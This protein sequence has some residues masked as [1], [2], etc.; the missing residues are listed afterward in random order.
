MSQNR[1]NL[2]ARFLLEVAAL[3]SMGYWG[4]RQGE[5]A[6]RFLIMLGV[7]IFAAALW[8]IFRVPGDPG[9]APVAVP[10]F[11]RLILEAIFFIFA[12]WALYSSGAN[13]AAYVF[14]VI[15]VIHYGISYD[16]IKDLLL[17]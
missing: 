14:A 4:W 9:D 5:G 11:I 17:G 7:P 16:R 6:I 13:T 12:I 2:A 15:V 3:V 1:I 8:G 10:G